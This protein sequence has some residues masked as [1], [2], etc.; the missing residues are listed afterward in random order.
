MF[1]IHI[2]VFLF[3]HT[4]LWK[5]VDTWNRSVWWAAMLYHNIE[6]KGLRQLER[7]FLKQLWN[8]WLLKNCNLRVLLFW[9]ILAYRAFTV[10]FHRTK[11]S[12]W[13]TLLNSLIY[14]LLIQS[15]SWVNRFHIKRPLVLKKN[16]TWV[17]RQSF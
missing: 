3:C 7:S 15:T 13:S 16:N 12:A 17:I 5:L 6:I 11:M 8:R 14:L 1:Q 10:I 9:I 4:K 2:I